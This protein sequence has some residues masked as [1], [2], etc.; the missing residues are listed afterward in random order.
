MNLSKR[1]KVLQESQIDIESMT[2]DQ[3]IRFIKQ[4]PSILKRPIILNEDNFQV[5][6]DEEE[7]GVFVPSELR[8]IAANN[9]TNKCPSYKACG[10]IVKDKEE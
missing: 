10:S 2:T 5:G 1:S 8:R 4:N 6:Y 3:L 9:C 7:I